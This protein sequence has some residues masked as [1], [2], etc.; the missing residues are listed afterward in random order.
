VIY[1]VAAHSPTPERCATEI[2]G[3]IGKTFKLWVEPLP[4][5]WVLD[6]P[7]DADQILVGL[8]PTLKPADRVVIIKAGTDARWLRL[9]PTTALWMAH[10]F[11]NAITEPTAERDLP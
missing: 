3:W 9:E 5:L 2:R 11:P 8:E 1:L 4:Q 6:G 10:A 7:L